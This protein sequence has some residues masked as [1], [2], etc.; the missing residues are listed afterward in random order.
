MV[1]ALLTFRCVPNSRNES[2]FEIGLGPSHNGTVEDS[3]LTI[4]HRFPVTNNLSIISLP[5]DVELRQERVNDKG[6]YRVVD[7]NHA[8]DVKGEEVPTNPFAFSCGLKTDFTFYPNGD[9][10]R[11]SRDA[12]MKERREAKICEDKFIAHTSSLRLRNLRVQLLI[13][14]EENK[15]S[16][17][18]QN[19]MQR[20]RAKHC[21]HLPGD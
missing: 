2:P 15:Y 11:I 19:G 3:L 21:Y 7:N 4:Q 10:T 6:R 5:Q 13:T 14:W 17:E 8:T 9:I 18:G 20:Q 12:R 16:N 1:V